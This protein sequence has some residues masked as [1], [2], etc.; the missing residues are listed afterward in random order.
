MRQ[1][2]IASASLIFATSFFVPPAHAAAGGG[3]YGDF[4]STPE[5][6]NPFR[7]ARRKIAKKQFAEAI[8]LLKEAV[9][10]KPNNPDIW[11]YLGYASRMT[12][13]FKNSLDYY[14]KALAIDP[15]HKDARE[16][17]GELYLQ[18]KNPEAAKGQLA[19]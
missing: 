10:E 12:G 16:Y 15:D 11:N 1:L 9:N 4:S 14:N 5:K 3:Y 17:L 13:D 19:E 8:P 7:D 18:T 6:P 2:L